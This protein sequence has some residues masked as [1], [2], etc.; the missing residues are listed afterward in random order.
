MDNFGLGQVILEVGEAVPVLGQVDVG[1]GVGC[2]EVEVYALEVY[3][4]GGDANGMLA[5]GACDERGGG[6]EGAGVGRG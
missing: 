5:R 1:V 2:L 3:V 6:R 4:G